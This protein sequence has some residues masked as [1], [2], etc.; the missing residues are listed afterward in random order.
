MS[1]TFLS[2]TPD[3]SREP[4]EEGARSGSPSTSGFAA[5]PSS[6]RT[7][8]S[9]RDLDPLSG[10]RKLRGLSDVTG[11]PDCSARGATTRIESAAVTMEPEFGV[12]LGFSSQEECF[13]EPSES[14]FFCVSQCVRCLKRCRVVM[15]MMMMM[16]GVLGCVMDR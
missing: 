1:V 11:I 6:S 16:V 4:S 7:F 5:G 9:T 13:L 10:D 15:M 8:C 14:F 3:L 12:L 2:C